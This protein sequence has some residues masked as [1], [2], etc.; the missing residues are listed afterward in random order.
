MTWWM[1]DH[2]YSIGAL[3]HQVSTNVQLDLVMGFNQVDGFLLLFLG[4]FFFCG[5]INM[6][7]S[8]RLDFILIFVLY[9]ASTRGGL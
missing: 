8:S 7:W 5:I 4:F 1:S 2:L 9:V 6:F 3:S